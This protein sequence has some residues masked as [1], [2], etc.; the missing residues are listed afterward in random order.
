M[1]LISVNRDVVGT[2]AR[3]LVAVLYD[4]LNKLLFFM[5]ERGPS[6]TPLTSHPYL[7]ILDASAT[8]TV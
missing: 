6:D 2:L 8:H 1:N 4:V 7:V 3:A 5:C